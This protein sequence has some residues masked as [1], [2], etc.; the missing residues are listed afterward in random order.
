M[1]KDGELGDE[2]SVL[3][4]SRTLGTGPF[5]LLIGREFKLGIW[6]DLAKSMR[7]GEIARF[8]CPFKVDVTLVSVGPHFSHVVCVCLP[9]LVIEYPRVSK[10][11]RELALKKA[12]KEVPHTHSHTCGFGA[13]QGTGYADL[14]RLYHDRHPLAFELELLRVDQP[15]EYKKESWAMSVD[16]KDKA[17]VR[18]R[19][20]GNV[21]Y[22]AGNHGDASK[23]YFEALGYLEELSLRQQPK[24]SDWREIEQRKIPLLLNYSQCMLLKKDYAEVIRHTTTVLGVD[25]DNVKAL[26]RRAKAHAASWDKESAEEDFAQVVRLDPSLARSAQRE[27]AQ[28]EEK[29]EREQEA[30]RDRWQGKLF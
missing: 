7:L 11:L 19:E 23:K 28:L 3:D 22:K 17:V 2:Q 14:D 26:Y 13:M 1:D 21:L 29:L 25:G 8:K 6:E 15:G 12:G 24:S 4:D 30:E 9:Q 20:E 18:L 10:A 27:L 5:E 16:E